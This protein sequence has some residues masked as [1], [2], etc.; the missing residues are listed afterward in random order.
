M[1]ENAIMFSQDR[2]KWCEMPQMGKIGIK[3]CEMV[4]N[5]MKQGGQNRFKMPQNG[6]KHHKTEA[7][8]TKIATNI[9]TC[10]VKWHK[11]PKVGQ[12]Q[13]ISILR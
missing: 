11:M 12:K 9:W 2:A 6:T 13:L 1:D 8:C 5:T 4:E 7:R 3:C 10:P